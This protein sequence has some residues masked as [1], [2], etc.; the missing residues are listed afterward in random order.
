MNAIYQKYISMTD[1]VKE[2]RSV[3]HRCSAGKYCNKNVWCSVFKHS[4]TKRLLWMTVRN[5]CQS[6]NSHNILFY[7]SRFSRNDKTLVSHNAVAVSY[8]AISDTRVRNEYWAGSK[9][10]NMKR[11]QVPRAKFPYPPL[12]CPSACTTCK[13]YK[14]FCLPPWPKAR[15]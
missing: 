8:N 6:M 1:T 7:W 5:S 10:P 14:S 2:P 12:Q 13:K 15:Y 4:P 11:L 9:F 3:L